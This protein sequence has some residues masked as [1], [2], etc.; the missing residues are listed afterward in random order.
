VGSP[1]RDRRQRGARQHSPQ[2]LQDVDVARP[3]STAAATE[4]ALASAAVAVPEFRPGTASDQADGKCAV[5]L[6]AG[7]VSVDK[8]PCR[9]RKPARILQDAREGRFSTLSLRGSVA[10]AD[11]AQQGV[12][13]RARCS[14]RRQSRCRTTGVRRRITPERE[15]PGAKLR[16]PATSS[17]LLRTVSVVGCGGLLVVRMSAQVS[18]SDAG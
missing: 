8:H 5:G 18:G 9:Q 17:V 7:A 10:P 2:A 11:R 14:C 15:R 1:R 16:R 12:G 13:L 6:L 3:V 4:Q